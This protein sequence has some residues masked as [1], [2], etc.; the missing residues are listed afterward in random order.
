M[1]IIKCHECGSDVSTEAAACPKCGAPVKNGPSNIVKYGGGFIAVLIAIGTFAGLSKKSEQSSSNN[2][3][4]AAAPSDP[5]SEAPAATAATEQP[6]AK[7]ERNWA[8]LPEAIE[9][10]RPLMSDEYNKVSAGATLLG[11]W[12]L[13][14]MKWEDLSQL[15]RTK[16]ALV[17]KSPDM[18]RGKLICISGAII[19]ILSEHVQGKE[20]S[21]G[22]MFDDA[23]G[24]YRFVNPGSSGT[25]VERSRAAMCGVVIGKFDYQNSMN[26]TAHSIQLVGMFDLPETRKAPPPEPEADA[27]AP[28]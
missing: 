5:S 3:V 26:G 6:A 22:G 10:V 21:Q 16:R 18:E 20:I 13:G 12:G 24:L 19:E 27:S 7:P 15:P 9:G 28:E 8:T 11:V 23:G 1:S 14:R 2:P 17:M 25:L 4:S